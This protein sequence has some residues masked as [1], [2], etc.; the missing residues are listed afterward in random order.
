MLTYITET[1]SASSQVTHEFKYTD[2]AID[3]I[4]RYYAED[5]SLQSVAGQ[6]NVN[7]SYL[8]RLFKQEKK[9]NFISYLTR[10]RIDHA[11]AFLLSKELRIYEIADKV[12]YHNYTYFSKIFKRTQGLRQRNIGNSSM[13]MPFG[14]RG[15]IDEI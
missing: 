8:S 5:L 7:P 10:V 2:L 12:G 11:K 4:N 6:I 9:E 1:F 15:V 14:N 13:C 3:I